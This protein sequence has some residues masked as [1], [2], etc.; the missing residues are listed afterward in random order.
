[1]NNCFSREDCDPYFFDPMA[2]AEDRAYADDSAQDLV[3]DRIES[4]LSDLESGDRNALGVAFESIGPDA[5]P[6]A[7]MNDIAIKLATLLISN[8]DGA[9]DAQIG[10]IIRTHAQRYIFSCLDIEE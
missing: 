6:T 3:D 7:Q 8:P 5:W 4:F 1:M 2:E 10:K 9:A